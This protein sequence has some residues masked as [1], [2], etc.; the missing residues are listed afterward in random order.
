MGTGF[1]LLMSI[2][3]AFTEHRWADA[4]LASGQG[5]L[6]FIGQPSSRHSQLWAEKSSYTDIVRTKLL[7]AVCWEIILINI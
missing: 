3:L 1:L 7:S 5:L 2:Q 6:W 4:V